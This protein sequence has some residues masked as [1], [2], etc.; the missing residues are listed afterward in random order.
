MLQL[1][2]HN[3]QTIPGWFDFDW[4]YQAAVAAAY[5]NAKLVEVGAFLGRSSS[6]L[7]T[8]AA[9]AD[10]DLEVNIVDLWWGSSEHHFKNYMPEFMRNMAHLRG[11]FNPIRLPSTV[12]AGALGN[13]DFV[14]LDA[15]HTRKALS[16]D[17]RAWRNTYP[18]IIAGH[19]Y[20]PN[21]FTGVCEAVHEAFGDNFSV[22]GST[23]YAVLPQHKSYIN[24]RKFRDA[25]A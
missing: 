14:F 23:W 1:I 6:Y 2:T 21:Q 12:A 20:K 13:T 11:H 3:Y 5:P 19:D 9:N 24:I 25:I 4:I 10:K 8:E 15:E 22:R 17:I 7:V 16:A 18:A